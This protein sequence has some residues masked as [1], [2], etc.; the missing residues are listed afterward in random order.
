MSDPRIVGPLSA[1]GVPIGDGI[2]TF[3]QKTPQQRCQSL[4]SY[5]TFLLWWCAYLWPVAGDRMGALL[6]A[7]VNAPRDLWM[8]VAAWAGCA[9]AGIVLLVVGVIG[10]RGS[11]SPLA[12]AWRVLLASCCIA[13][14]WWPAYPADWGPNGVFLLKGLYG[15]WLAMNLV[16]LWIVAGGHGSARRVMR[17]AMRQR[18]A[19]LRPATARR[20]F[21]W[22]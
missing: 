12:A 22:W 8:P 19:P 10:A 1:I 11:W 7:S 16:R 13:L 18:N 21:F 20:R 5:G 9:A 6:R 3:L 2:N 4:A 15:S 14:L 17:R